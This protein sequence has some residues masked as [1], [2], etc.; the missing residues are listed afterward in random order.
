MFVFCLFALLAGAQAQY[1]NEPYFDQPDTIRHAHALNLMEVRL[2]AMAAVLERQGELPDELAEQAEA[3]LAHDL[4]RLAG[5]LAESH[6][7]LLASLREALEGVEEAVEAGGADPLSQEIQVAIEEVTRARA[8]LLSGTLEQPPL[9]AAA[10]SRLLLGEP[11][12]GEGYEE[13]VQ[14]ERW[15][16]TLGWSALQRVEEI[17]AELAP[18]V[19]GRSD[20]VDEALA[21]LAELLAGPVPPDS[22][23]GDP[24]AGEE[25]AHRI[26]S[27][28]E[29]ITDSNLYP[30]RELGRVAALG[31]EQ[32]AAACSAFE[33]GNE[34]LGSEYGLAVADAYE[35]I[36]D[37][38]GMLAS[39]AHEQVEGA[40]ATLTGGS[41]EEEDEEKEASAA[42]TDR[43]QDTQVEFPDAATA[44]AALQQGLEEIAGAFGG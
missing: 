15:E 34:P 21:E 42:A 31:A 12:V 28:L 25:P 11:G 19:A 26:T 17:W 4:P 2:D 30:E 14:G 22:L 23:S 35:S 41:E 44:C 36:A 27:L 33:S 43:G 20:E 6:E 1:S 40:L 5:S 29:G 38:V 3:L 24:E 18:D 13:A 16:Y 39:E 7:E 10:M 8:E 32:A 37:T 9:A